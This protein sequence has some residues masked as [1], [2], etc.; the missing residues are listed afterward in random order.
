MLLARSIQPNSL[1]ASFTVSATTLPIASR[2]VCGMRMMTSNP[3]WNSDWSES[4]MISLVKPSLR[5]GHSVERWM[6]G[7]IWVRKLNLKMLLWLETIPRDLGN[8]SNHQTPDHTLYRTCLTFRELTIGNGGKTEW[9]WLKLSSSLYI[10]QVSYLFISI[11]IPNPCKSL[12]TPVLPLS[13]G[14]FIEC[15]ATW[16]VAIPPPLELNQDRAISVV[17][18][19]WIPSLLSFV[20][21]RTDKSAVSGAIRLQINVEIKG[22]EKVAPYHVQ[23]T[24]LHEVSSAL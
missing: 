2:Y 16:V 21:K 12:S 19:L 9:Q 18:L 10:L 20:E 7:T 23:Y 5:F 3:E 4:L 15:V 13:T 17:A 6:S 11:L 1:P 24:C 14:L 8:L 22:E